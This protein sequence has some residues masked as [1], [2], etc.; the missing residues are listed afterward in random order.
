MGITGSGKTTFINILM[1][2]QKPSGGEILVDGRNIFEKKNLEY[3][4]SWR[5][6]INHV[7]QKIYLTNSTFE[8]NNE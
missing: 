4:Y 3:L 8:S 7:P 2:V 1:G 5:K 6:N